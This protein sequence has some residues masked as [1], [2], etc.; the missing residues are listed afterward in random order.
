MICPLCDSKEFERIDIQSYKLYQC[1]SCSLQYF[2]DNEF[3]KDQNYL[4]IY[5]K[6]RDEKSIFSKLRQVQYSIDAEHL[7]KNIPKGNI[8]DVG[9]STGEFLNILSKFSELHLYG[10]D[11]DSDAISIAKTKGKSSINFINTDIINYQTDL[12]FDCIIFRG[13]FQF[14]GH[15]LKETFKKI[16]K[17]SSKNCKIII[18]SLPNSDSILYYLLKDNWHLFDKFSQTL[19]FNKRS[20][21]KLCKIYNYKIYEY[22]YPYLETPY[23]NYLEN[24]E[25]LLQLIKGEKKNSFPFW[26]N[27]MQIVLEK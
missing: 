1:N 5:S 11:T 3:D 14:L 10:I 20:I 16:S 15:D 23:A 9:C 25:N 17:I 13:S 7:E 22:S 21:M 18:Y 19:I 26:G 27:I 12:K 6:S 24:Y 4:N 8:L 2:N